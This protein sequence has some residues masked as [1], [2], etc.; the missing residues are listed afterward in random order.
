MITCTYPIIILNVDISFLLNKVFYNSDIGTFSCQ[1][2]GSHLMEKKESNEVNK[3]T[4]IKEIWTRCTIQFPGQKSSETNNKPSVIEC[5]DV[6]P[7]YNFPVTIHYTNF[8]MTVIH[9]FTVGHKTDLEILNTGHIT[10]R[11]RVYH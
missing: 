7:V 3:W 1:V 10:S 6:S 8:L 4:F 5:N 2:Q 9:L 11:L